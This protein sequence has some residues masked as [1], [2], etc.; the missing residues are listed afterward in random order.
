MGV[1]KREGRVSSARVAFVAIGTALLVAAV[2]AVVLVAAH[3]PTVGGKWVDAGSGA[4]VSIE[5]GLATFQGLYLENG[6]W[7]TASRRCEHVGAAIDGHGVVT[8]TASAV[9]I[10]S[11]DAG[12]DFEIKY[13]GPW[14]DKT[15]VLLFQECGPDRP[16]VT[17]ERRD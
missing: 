9:G 7:D 15:R 1:M 17:L 5:D 16:A 14:W 4:T 10:F 3:V 8:A 2:T 12:W 6:E 13:G 11:Q